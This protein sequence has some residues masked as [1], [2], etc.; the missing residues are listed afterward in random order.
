MKLREAVNVPDFLEREKIVRRFKKI[1]AEMVLDKN[2]YE[3]WNSLHPDERQFDT[4]FWDAAIA[5]CDALGDGPTPQP[6]DFP[7]Y[8]DERK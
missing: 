7:M 1:R 4:T 8:K 6:D 5:W 3:H 2:T